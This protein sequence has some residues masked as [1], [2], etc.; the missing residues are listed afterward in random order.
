MSHQTEV[1]SYFFFV[2][3]LFCLFICLSWFYICRYVSF[4]YWLLS[5]SFYFRS[6]AFTSRGSA[7][8]VFLVQLYF[9]W[10]EKQYDNVKKGEK[11]RVKYNFHHARI[12]A[13]QI[14]E[15]INIRTSYAAGVQLCKQSSVLILPGENKW[16]NNVIWWQE[17]LRAF[18]MYRKWRRKVIEGGKTGSEWLARFRG[19]GY[20]FKALE[21]A[22]HWIF[23]R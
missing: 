20:T 14:W 8:H 7:I 18:V 23:A 11:K 4:C 16:L 15:N 10:R 12:V 22:I 17:N 19:F 9:R 1:D 21:N 2:V 3:V 13:T 5:L 6:L